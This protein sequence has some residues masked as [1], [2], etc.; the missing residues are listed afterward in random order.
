[1]VSRTFQS[2]K[3]AIFPV[4][5]DGSDSEFQR[6][7]LW[8]PA[9]QVQDSLKMLCIS[10]VRCMFEEAYSMSCGNDM[11]LKTPQDA[12][13]LWKLKPCPRKATEEKHCWIIC[14]VNFLYLHTKKDGYHRKSVFTGFL[15]SPLFMLSH[16]VKNGNRMDSFHF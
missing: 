11:S 15:D 12:V 6:A 1:M 16:R 7:F 8:L 14:S 9:V 2:A 10:F 3:A 4:P 13:L 5:F